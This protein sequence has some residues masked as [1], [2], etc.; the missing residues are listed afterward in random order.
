VLDVIRR[1][2]WIVVL[3]LACTAML[4]SIAAARDA[5]S[6]MVAARAAFDRNLDAIRKKDRDAY[7]ACYLNA[8]TLARSGPGGMLL[9]Y[10]QHAQQSSDSPWP[11]LFEGKDLK[12]VSVDPGIVYGTYR[13]RVV[14]G[15]DEHTGLSERIFLETPAGWK[16]AMTSAFDAP[17]GT[18]PPPRALTGG[19]LWDGSGDAV[20][21]DA[22]VLMRGGAIECAGSRA[23]CAV[24]DGV[25]TMDVSG[26][27]IV[28]GLI[29]AHV[30][31]GQTGWADGRP[32]AIDVRDL[33]PYET[34]Q[35]DLRADPESR[36]RAYLCSGVTSVFDVGG[37]PWTWDLRERA[38]DDTMAPRVAAAGPL[39][40]TLDHW[41][42]LPAE[43]QF[44]HLSS[45]QAARDGVRYLAAAGTDAA[46]VWFIVRPENDFEALEKVVRA[47]ASEAASRKLP[48]IVHATGL[49]EAKSA[50]AAGARMLVHSVDDL[51]VDD[52]FL[53]NARRNGTIYCPTL[54]VLRGYL[55]MFES[56]ATG[57]PAA[58][59]D[60]HGCVDA[61]TLER[62]AMSARM[63]EKAPQLEALARIAERT[64]QRE[65]VMAENLMRVHAAGIRIAMG[66]DAG[67][68]L[69]LHGPSVHAEMEAMQAAGLTPLEVLRAATSGSAAAMGRDEDLGTLTK[70]KKA[71]LI[72]LSADPMADAKN[73][74]SI[75][76]VVR[77]GEIREARE[78]AAAAP[79]A[80]PR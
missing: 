77:G 36:F 30:H 64:K 51:A 12:L 9:G 28:P 62:V 74:R 80:P 58:V 33:F 72:I 54:T 19:T 44:I 7:L 66:T 49:K 52:E 78:L 20:V 32:D 76:W 22:V 16:I 79:A 31:F 63:K 10:E 17:K 71:D 8:E 25:E 3:A 5:A 73:L 60:P 37:Y 57:A 68:P 69:T 42:N 48:M 46:K 11:D 34:V 67:N 18:P 47:A 56:A 55:R 61:R 1:A 27:W 4:S 53:A 2:S 40:T 15:I 13:Y 65:R 45:E 75:R 41:L 26:H 35:A 59:D 14:Y 21:R 39:L 50:L 29:D 24:P 43:R 23:G 70:G 38:E 6:D